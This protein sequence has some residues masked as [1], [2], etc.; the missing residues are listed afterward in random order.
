MANDQMNRDDTVG[1]S[2]EERLAQ[3]KQLR[4]RASRSAHGTWKPTEDRPDP[5]AM[6]IES[7]RGRLESLAPIRHARMLTSPFAFFRGSAAAMAFDLAS[8]PVSGLRAQL[9]G[10][11]HLGNF[12]GFATPE[13]RLIIDLMDFDETI[14]G[15]WEWDVKR[16]GTSFHL[17][18]RDI[19]LGESNCE[20]A[21]LNLGRAY[22]QRLIELAQMKTMDVF[23]GSI[24]VDTFVTQ[25]RDART[26]KAREQM[27]A[28]ARKQTSEKFFAKSVR[29][30]N[31]RWR[32]VDDPP[33]LFHPPQTDR[34][35]A[36]FRETFEEYKATLS[37]DRRMLLQRF[38]IVDVAMKV[39]GVGSVGTRCGVIL[40]MAGDDDPLI[41]QV[42]EARRSVLEQFV[43]RSQ[44]ENMGQRVVMGQRLL[45]SSS[46]IFLG[47]G[48]MAGGQHYYIRQLRDMKK[49]PEIET[50]WAD[51]LIDTA[52]ICGWALAQAHARSGDAAR[53]SGY[54]GKSEAFDLA[55]A[56]FSRAYA[57][58]S[59][60]DYQVMRAAVKSG[61]LAVDEAVINQ[62]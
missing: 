53:I 32:I 37:D 22:R 36:E 49:G 10:D 7:G 33:F 59:E 29:L 55:L 9:C 50:Y 28:K 4:Q 61:K 13:R 31:G 48:K 27:I 18:G 44:Y 52:E 21:V 2:M 3:G 58:Q 62:A 19:G 12:G 5:V 20:E 16:L 38:D 56:A 14:P 15:P 34:F 30:M 60:K 26:R 41:L 40:L 25:S 17:V 42:K 24:G 1:R 45:Q 6:L 23:Y 39:A 51:R 57:D 8:T 11:C 43:G 47:W 54:L 35:N 46:D